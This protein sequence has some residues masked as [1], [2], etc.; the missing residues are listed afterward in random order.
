MPRLTPIDPATA[1]GEAKDLLDGIQAAFGRTPNSF[2]A[3]ANNPAVLKGW[4]QLSGA[5]GKTLPRKLAEQVAIAI[6]EQNGCAY[7]LSAHSAVA[8]SL[9]I[10]A[11][12][13]DD[14]R[15]GDSDDERV[16]AALGFALTVNA[17]RGGV[18]D[19]D[20][21]EVRAAG[22][23]DADI[24]AIVAHVAL[25]VLTNYFNRVA[26]PVIDFPEVTPRLAEVA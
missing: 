6:A 23:D 13:I 8:G 21:A 17:K 2:R 11:R 10:G 26:Q 16:A 15:S 14:N 12:E 7:C 5:L 3:M 25:N 19:T 1:T 18:S 9:G 22:Y 24:A 20:L 4:I